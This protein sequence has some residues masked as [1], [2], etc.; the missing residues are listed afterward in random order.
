MNM[1]PTIL[2]IEVTKKAIKKSLK[3]SNDPCFCP[4]ACSI[5]SQLKIKEVFVHNDGVVSIYLPP[6]SY[7]LSGN[8]QKWHRSLWSKRVKNYRK[9]LKPRTITLRRIE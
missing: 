3:D 4:I 8:S 5:K 9:D 7:R 2:K 1:L 6:I